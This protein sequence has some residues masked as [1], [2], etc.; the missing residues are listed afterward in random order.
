MAVRRLSALALFVSSVARSAP[1]PWPYDGFARFPSLWFGANDTQIDDDAILALASRHALAGIGWQQ[2]STRAQYSHMEAE[3]GAAAR[4]LSAYAAKAPLP[5]GAAG[6]VPVFTYR[7]MQEIWDA[8][9]VQA[10]FMRNGANNGAF[11]HDPVSGTLC[12][13][14]G[15][16]EYNH[17]S[18]FL[19]WSNATARAFF[20]DA[21]VAEAAKEAGARAVFFDE[22]D[23][24][25]CGMDAFW[26]SFGCPNMTGDTALIEADQA[27]KAPAFVGT[28]AQL[29]AHS[30]VPI[31][32]SKN[33]LAAAWD[34]L[35][36]APLARPC[37]PNVT[38]DRLYDALDSAG[39]TVLRFYEFWMSGGDVNPKNPNKTI[40]A[41]YNAATI[42]NAILEGGRGIGFVARAQMFPLS[43]CS[44]RPPPAD[45]RC[46]QISAPLAPAFA[47][48]P[49][50][51]LAGPPYHPIPDLEFAVAAF[52]VAQAPYSYFGGSSGWYS[53]CW[54]YLDVYDRAAHCGAP[55]SPAVRSGAY[56][57]QRKF[58][59]CN[60]TVD[61]EAGTG[62]IVYNV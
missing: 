30:K 48:A 10:A 22:T 52:L 20:V 43:N 2:G 58:S 3:I 13:A 40:A 19:R 31:F 7:N 23:A 24:N 62:S 50:A 55:L 5:P 51:R 61:A 34:G 57:W 27:A 25:A 21:E 18:Y 37:L 26:G 41:A 54:C 35:P 53:S 17:T 28:A 14:A 9:D 46:D 29:N 60:V 12:V 32:S 39:V 15:A 49:A 42:A 11:L 4:A 1:P 36:R 59:G 47:R 33:F 6:P 8:F 44:S 45:G 38:L 16:G 56:T